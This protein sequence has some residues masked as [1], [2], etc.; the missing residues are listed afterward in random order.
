M[1]CEAKR[2]LIRVCFR[3][4]LL[5]AIYVLAHVTCEHSL[6]ICDIAILTFHSNVH[7]SFCIII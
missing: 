4:K 5:L 6:H 2:K 1:N 3:V 7:S